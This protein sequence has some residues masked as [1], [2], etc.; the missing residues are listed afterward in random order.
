MDCHL[1][2][3]RRENV[4]S[5]QLRI[6]IPPPPPT[7]RHPFVYPFTGLAPVYTAVH[8]AVLA[9]LHPCI[10]PPIHSSITSPIHQSTH[11]SI[12][13]FTHPFIYPLIHPSV[14]PYVHL[15]VL[16]SIR[17]SIHSSFHPSIHPSIHASIYQNSAVYI[18]NRPYGKSMSELI[19][20]LAPSF[21]ARACGSKEA[22]HCNI[23]CGLS[24]HAAS[25][26]KGTDTRR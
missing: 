14:R 19:M 5:Y 11:P 6:S 7:H 22:S 1:H 3:R 10:R 18:R 17:P 4:K 15:S 26:V 13:Q 12:Y 9:Y 16:P 23:Y 8:P 21:S 25:V 20:R 24:L 2:T